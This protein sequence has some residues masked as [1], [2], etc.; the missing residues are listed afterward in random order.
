MAGTALVRGLDSRVT[1]AKL[2]EIDLATGKPKPR[3]NLKDANDFSKWD[4]VAVCWS[5]SARERG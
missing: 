1:N 2:V 4:S 5:R 3:N